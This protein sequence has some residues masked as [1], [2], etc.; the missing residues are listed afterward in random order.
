VKLTRRSTLAWALAWTG[1]AGARAAPR[2]RFVRAAP[3]GFHLEG[4][5]FPFAGANL[6]CGPYLGA[7]ADFGDRDR[8]KRELDR[9]AALG[10]TS[11]RV[12]GASEASPLKHSVTPAF[13][14]PG[15]PYDQR[16]LRGL[17]FLLA[18]MGAR[19]LRAV[20]YLTNFWEWSGGMMAYLYWTNGGQYLDM[21][22]PAHPWPQFPDF[23][24]RFYGSER[25]VALYERHVRAIV[26]R[27]NTVTGRRYTEDPAI[28]AW[29]LANEPRPGGSDAAADANMAAFTGW[30]ARTASLIKRLDPNHLVSTGSE[31]LKGCVE[32][33][34]CV[35]AA[36]SPA[37]VDYLTAHIWPQNW[38]WIDPHDLGGTHDKAQALTADY[39]ARH[40][41]FARQLGKPL[42]IEE[43]GYPRDGGSYEPGSPTTFKDR[44]YAQIQSAV[45]ASVQAG[46]PLAGSMFWAWAGEGRAAH[47]DH[48]FRP[49]DRAWLGDPPHEPQGWYSVFDVDESTK[50]LIGA[51]AAALRRASA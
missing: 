12:L 5:P 43:F 4:R 47:P 28:L 18:E 32:Q 46:G 13:H 19:D 25:A 36:H 7:E 35:I 39:I 2:S 22:D 30:I 26:G 29:Q 10:I 48:Q 27:T 9:L 38:G 20:I 23:S 37:Q 1:Q 15:R 40:T 24:S 49:G 6:W 50:A 21:N 42:V 3:G 8:L 11:L 17:D 33:S 44:F 51:H 14:V 31:G 45:L 41:E 16:L 34:G